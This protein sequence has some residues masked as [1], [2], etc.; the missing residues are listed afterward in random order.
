M[1]LVKDVT[2][3]LVTCMTFYK[4]ICNDVL[5]HELFQSMSNNVAKTIKNRLPAFINVE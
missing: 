1:I 3:A 4:D 5:I 2:N